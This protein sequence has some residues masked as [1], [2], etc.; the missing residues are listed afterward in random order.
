[1]QENDV[2]IIDYDAYDGDA[3]VEHASGTGQILTVGKSGLI[4]LDE[5]ILGMKLGEMRKF[6][7]Q[8][9]E[10][11]LPSIANKKLEFHITLV[12]G[13]KII[14]MPLNDELAKKAGQAT[15]DDLRK[16]VTGMVQAKQQEVER[17]EHAQQLMSHL[18]AKNAIK[19][20]T[21]LTLSEAQYLTTSA[22]AK[23]ETLMDTDKEEYLSTAEKN[24]KIALILDEI[25]SQEPEAQL[26]DQEILHSIEHNLSTNGQNKEQIDQA[27]LEL[28]KSGQLPILAARI[29]D[30]HTL[31]FL[32]KNTTFVD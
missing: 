15:L 26:S 32:L 27:M 14:P 11:A 29:K 2:V 10:N 6:I 8:M 13:S 18:L 30:E 28:N 7:I 5:N 12:M 31:D 16:F 19:I 23:W 3:K 20:P 24:V 4:G 25:R 9:P 1:V 21:W 22:G 17:T